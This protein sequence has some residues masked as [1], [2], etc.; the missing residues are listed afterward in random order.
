MTDLSRRSWLARGRAAC[1]R[2]N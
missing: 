1:A 2:R